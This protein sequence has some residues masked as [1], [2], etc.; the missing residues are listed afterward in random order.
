MLI[1]LLENYHIYQAADGNYY[2]GPRQDIVRPVQRPPTFLEW[3]IDGKINYSILIILSLGEVFNMM[4]GYRNS[5][6]HCDIG[7]KSLVQIPGRIRRQGFIGLHAVL[8]HGGLAEVLT[9]GLA[10]A[11][12]AGVFRNEIAEVIEE[13]VGNVLPNKIF[14]TFFR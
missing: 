8:G 3:I 5:Y 12:T 13:Y 7:I 14:L 4:S 9:I 11:L 10:G 6:T 2:T 1:L